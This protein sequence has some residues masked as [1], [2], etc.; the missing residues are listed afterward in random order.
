[1]CPN[2]SFVGFKRVRLYVAPR[3]E[4]TWVQ[5]KPFSPAVLA[6]WAECHPSRFVLLRRSHAPWGASVAKLVKTKAWGASVAK[7][8][9]TKAAHFRFMGKGWLLLFDSPRLHPN[10]GGNVAKLSNARNASV[11]SGNA[12]DSF[13]KVL[14]RR[15]GLGPPRRSRCRRW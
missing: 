14:T 7:L 9:K 1:M 10:R 12:L 13:E 4:H 3:R 11:R 15:R 5:S 2:I 6:Q 8:V